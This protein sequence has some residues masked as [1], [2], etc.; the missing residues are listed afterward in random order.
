VAKIR[1]AIQETNATEVCS[2]ISATNVLTLLACVGLGVKVV[3][4]ERNDLRRQN[5][6]Q[7]WAALRRM[8]YGQAHRVTANS[9]A[10]LA[11]MRAFV[12]ENKLLFVPNPLPDWSVPTPPWKNRDRLM[13]AVGRLHPQKGYDLLLRILAASNARQLGWRL[14][15]VG[16]GP[17]RA[18]LERLA[19]REVADIVTFVGQQPD[20]REWYDRARLFVMT[21]RY[22]GTPNAF[23][24]AL[25]RDLPTIVT[26]TCGDAASYVDT[27]GCGA[28]IDAERIEA[29]AA[30]LNRFLQ[31]LAT[32]RHKND[33]SIAKWLQATFGPA[34]VCSAWE[35]AFK[36]N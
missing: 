29:S 35:A 32:R 13:V 34:A 10:A 7:A 24:E 25:S 12:P 33:S 26:R 3:V 16:E 5:I 22:E 11:A 20:V 17:E 2:F 36:Q 28:I 19:S 8:V 31:N 23:I 18:V 21:S 30:V 4:S 6:G 27:L 14:A 9:H 15:I 1:R